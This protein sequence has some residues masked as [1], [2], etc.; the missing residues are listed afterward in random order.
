MRHRPQQPLAVRTSCPDRIESTRTEPPHH[1]TAHVELIPL[2]HILQHTGPQPVRRGRV[3][4]VRGTIGRAGDLADNRRPATVDDLVRAL[5]VVGPVAIQPGHEQDDGDAVRGA[6]FLGDPDVQRDMGA[7]ETRAVRVRHE[8][9]FD[10]RLPERRRF[11]VHL[12]LPLVGSAFHGVLGPRVR[13]DVGEA[14]D[15]QHHRC[16]SV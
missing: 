9:L 1:N 6:G 12:L 2:A 10:L 13:A 15:A 7:V 4:R 3:R 5:A 11:Q 8:H 14:R 16:A